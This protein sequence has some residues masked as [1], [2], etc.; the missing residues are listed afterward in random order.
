MHQRLG[1]KRQ[2]SLTK[3]E[4]GSLARRCLLSC[5]PLGK[6]TLARHRGQGKEGT[7]GTK[8]RE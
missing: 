6:D 4:R 1:D 5:N 2:A 7:S 8:H 3:G